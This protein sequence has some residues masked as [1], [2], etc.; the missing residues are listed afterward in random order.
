MDQEVDLLNDPIGASSAPV[1]VDGVVIVG[2]AFPS[3]F[4]PSSP[5]IITGHVLGVDAITGERRWIFHTI[6]Q[7]RT[8]ITKKP[9]NRAGSFS[10][11]I[12]LYLA[13]L[14]QANPID[15]KIINL[16][17]PDYTSLGL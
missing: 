4:A 1:V 2:S 5:E 15:Q 6:P 13:H 11:L 9:A 7:N 17:R 12:Y 16:H 10:D 8:Y 14:I 3:G